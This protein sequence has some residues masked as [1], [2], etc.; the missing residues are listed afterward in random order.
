MCA[1]HVQLCDPMDCSPAGSSVHGISQARILEW[2]AISFSR[3][4]SRPRDQAHVSCIAGGFLTAEP[5]GGPRWPDLGLSLPSSLKHQSFKKLLEE[6]F[7][8]FSCCVTALLGEHTRWL[9]GIE[10][11]CQ[12][13]D[14][15]SIPGS[16]RSHGKGNGNQLQYSCLGNP[17]DRGRLQAMGS[18]KS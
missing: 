16:G 15:G 12:A 5:P 6:R 11:S 1:S 9:R 8:C 10:S 13:G 2:I 17:V 7:P 18:Q 3:G 14:L 4:S